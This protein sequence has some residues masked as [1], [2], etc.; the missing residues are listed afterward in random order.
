VSITIFLTH[1]PLGH[2]PLGPPWRRDPRKDSW[3]RVLPPRPAPHAPHSQ[4][5]W[6]DC[7][8]RLVD[9]TN[10]LQFPTAFVMAVVGVV[11]SMVAA[12][13]NATKY[14]YPVS[15]NRELVALGASNL[16]ASLVTATGTLPIF[17]SLTRELP[18]TGC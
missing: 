3:R 6:R 14:G 9:Q 10:S 4:V 11:D 15:P 13:E 12:R 1:S 2:L 5:L 7:E 18:P 16:V 8:L 17:G